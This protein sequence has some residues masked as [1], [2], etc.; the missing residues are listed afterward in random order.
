MLM[1]AS[2]RG[3]QPLLIIQTAQ[4]VNKA[5]RW[6]HA[7]CIL[8]LDSV[9]NRHK[10]LQCQSTHSLL[11]AA[12]IGCRAFVLTSRTVLGSCNLHQVGI[13]LILVAGFQVEGVGAWWQPE[14]RSDSTVNRHISKLKVTKCVKRHVRSAK[15]F[16]LAAACLRL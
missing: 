9:H 15:G 6:L 2:K 11:S 13:H 14:D 4:T 1:C 10:L 16:P 7:C 3:M 12:W 8:K 5:S